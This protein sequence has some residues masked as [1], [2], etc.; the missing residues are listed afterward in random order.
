MD[1]FILPLSGYEAVLDIHWLKQFGPIVCDFQ[2]LTLTIEVGG[3]SILLRGL[4][5]Q[6]R[7][8]SIVDFNENKR[9]G[10]EGILFHIQGDSLS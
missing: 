4:Q 7:L 10:T 1:F 2:Q 5:S 3:K 8:L 9:L 6:P